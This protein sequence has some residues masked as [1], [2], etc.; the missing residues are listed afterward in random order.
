V[1]SFISILALDFT[2]AVVFKAIYN[3]FY[4]YRSLV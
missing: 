3:T 2:L 1:S 4:S